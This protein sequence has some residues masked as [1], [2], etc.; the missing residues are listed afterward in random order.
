MIG[1][2][3]SKSDVKKE[4]E[5]SDSIDGQGSKIKLENKDE[6]Q[7][8]ILENREASNESCSTSIYTRYL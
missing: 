8:V 1:Q 7:Q 2:K 5:N 4:A 6:I 3:D